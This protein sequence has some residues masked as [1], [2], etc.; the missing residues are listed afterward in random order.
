ML[1]LLSGDAGTACSSIAEGST[2]RE[3]CL[4]PM[5]NLTIP[6]MIVATAVK[7]ITAQIAAS[8]T[9]SLPGEVE[10]G[11]SVIVID[12]VLVVFESEL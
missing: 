3:T 7:A 4:D 2:L 6:P 5:A 12:I 8:T 10:P 9:W 1:V 11:S